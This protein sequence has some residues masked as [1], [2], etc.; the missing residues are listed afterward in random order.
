MT[1]PHLVKRGGQAELV[2]H[3]RQQ[4][5][6]ER[7]HVGH[8]LVELVLERREQLGGRRRVAVEEVP[9]T[10]HAEPQPGQ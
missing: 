3:R 10:L 8:P 2:E 5:V 4:A 1:S 7:A 9:C 6:G